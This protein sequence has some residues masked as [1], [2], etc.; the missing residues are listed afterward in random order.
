V[1]L[2]DPSRAASELGWKPTVSF[3]DGLRRT[4]DWL[5]D[6][7]DPRVAEYGW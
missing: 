2:S 1:L 4:A 3:A 7:P 6:H 5:R